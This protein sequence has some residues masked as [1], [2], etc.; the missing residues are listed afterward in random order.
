MRLTEF[1]T[2]QIEVA[3]QIGNISGTLFEWPELR[4]AFIAAGHDVNPRIGA[5]EIRI[6]AK[7]ILAQ[8]DQPSGD[9]MTRRMRADGDAE[10]LFAGVVAVCLICLW[11]VVISAMV[12]SMI[13]CA[14]LP[15]PDHTAPTGKAIARADTRAGII[16]RSTQEPPTKV[17][18]TEIR[19]DLKDADKA[20]TETA[21]ELAAA[22]SYGE[23]Q[24]NTIWNKIGRAIIRI[25]IVWG[26]VLLV[27]GVMGGYPAV[28][29]GAFG[30]IAR[31]IINLVPGGNVSAGI[32]RR[33]NSGA[34]RPRRK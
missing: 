25:G 33:I 14:S 10:R 17:L 34:W 2:R 9:G 27:A 3:A 12:F 7:R 6:I 19:A 30:K 26:A 29:G 20:N 24:Y 1:D 4:E 13:G 23:R 15:S 5:R 16:E 11:I 31:F 28:A 8:L 22:I 32:S 21:K 18:A